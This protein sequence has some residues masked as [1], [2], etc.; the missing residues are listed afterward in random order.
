[1]VKKKNNIIQFPKKNPRAVTVENVIDAIVEN[2]NDVAEVFSEEA[3]E[4]LG[5]QFNACGFEA[6]QRYQKDWYFI[7]EAIRSLVLK[8][9]GCDHCIQEYA[10]NAVVIEK[11]EDIEIFNF[12]TLE[13][14]LMKM[15]EAE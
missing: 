15:D 2:A 8:L 12:L 6:S 4:C 1:M 11:E 7:A 3:M 9:K 14:L 5:E 13:E 10:S